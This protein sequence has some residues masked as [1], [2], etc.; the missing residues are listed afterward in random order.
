MA[1]KP[2]VVVSLQLQYA[3]LNE[4]LPSVTTRRSLLKL[5]YTIVEHY[6]HVHSLINFFNFICEKII[7]VTRTISAFLSV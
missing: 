1:R 3:V 7:V 5:I 2:A 6:Y 4:G